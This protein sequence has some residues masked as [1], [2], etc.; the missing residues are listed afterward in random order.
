MSNQNIFQ[1][2]SQSNFQSIFRILF[3]TSFF[4]TFT[5]LLVAQ[6]QK[7]AYK[8]HSGN[9]SKFRLDKENKNN[10]GLPSEIGA[11]WDLQAD[12]ISLIHF[13]TDS[14]AGKEFYKVLQKLDSEEEYR[15]YFRTKKGKKL[16]KQMG[17]DNLVYTLE[18]ALYSYQYENTRKYIL[19]LMD[20]HKEGTKKA[21][22]TSGNLFLEESKYQNYASLPIFIGFLGLALWLYKESKNS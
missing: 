14:I 16:K 10:I 4:M 5:F 7:I 12:S 18:T 6:T 20:R 3:F 21:N 1:S 11:F 19:E 22:D 8:S 15:T 2:I 17:K 9:S 13:L